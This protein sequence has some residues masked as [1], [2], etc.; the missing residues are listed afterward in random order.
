MDRSFG[1]PEELTSKGLPGGARLSSCMDVLVHRP[2]GRRRFE[3]RVVGL[4]PLALTHRI[5]GKGHEAFESQI[6]S[7]PL[8]L[9][10]AFLRVSGLEQHRGV[11]PRAVRAVEIGS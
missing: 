8:R 5:E 11:A 6:R 9:C 4:L 1:I 2:A 10:L 7:E 3:L